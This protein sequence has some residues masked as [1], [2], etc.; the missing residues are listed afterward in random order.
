[1]TQ[2]LRTCWQRAWDAHWLLYDWDYRLAIPATW[3]LIGLARLVRRSK[4]A[5]AFEQNGKHYRGF[6]REVEV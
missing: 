4:R 2:R 6:V 3:T 1:M 5:I